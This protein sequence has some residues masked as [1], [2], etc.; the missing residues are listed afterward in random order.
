[1]YDQST[2]IGDFLK[3]AAA[4]QPT[5]GGGSVTALA[6]ALAAAM[7]EMTL[8]YS[9]GRKGH[10]EF[11]D[12][13]RPALAEL[14]RA[15]GLLA[16]LMIEDQGVYEAM[17]KARKLPQTDPERQKRF[18]AALLACIRVPQAV[19]ATAV[20]I[21]ELVDRVTNFVNPHLLSDLAVCA[22]LAMATTRCAVYNVRANLPDLKD[23]ADRSTVEGSIRGLLTHAASLIQRVAPRIWERHE[24]ELGS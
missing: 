12:E 1:M 17:T 2:T 13:L 22:D 23:A 15:R 6:G 18:D 21:L 9:V 20:A 4:R 5:P 3:A 16:Q 14:T 19:A 7:G 8:N 10:E 24:Q 11:D